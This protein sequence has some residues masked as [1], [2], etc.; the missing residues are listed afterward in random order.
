[1]AEYREKY[2]WLLWTIA[3]TMLAYFYFPLT[4]TI[5]FFL[6]GIIISSKCLVE[7]FI[8]HQEDAEKQNEKNH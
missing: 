3:T 1:M 5:T 6:S 2:F 4:L 7:D 8:N